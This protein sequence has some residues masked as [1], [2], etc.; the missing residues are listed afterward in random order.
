[1]RAA[2]K[3]RL[4]EGLRKD[5]PTPDED[6]KI[7][8]RMLVLNE[9]PKAAGWLIGKREYRLSFHRRGMIDFHIPKH[10]RN[11]FPMWFSVAIDYLGEHAH[12]FEVSRAE[13][14]KLLIWRVKWKGWKTW[15]ELVQRM[16]EPS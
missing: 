9:G 4:V 14:A 8:R 12:S 2:T 1:M 6:R 7:A 13:T 16:R 5:P 10:R 3:L 15:K 11:E